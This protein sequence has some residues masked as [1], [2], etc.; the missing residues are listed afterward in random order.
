MTQIDDIY[1]QLVTRVVTEGQTSKGDIRAHYADG[2]PAHTVYIPNAISVTFT[3][4]MGLPII[5]TKPV[6]TKSMLAELDW[7]WRKMSNNVEEL[8]QA[9]ST[10]WDEWEKP[11]GT[12]GPAYGAQL[13]KLART[14]PDRDLKLNQVEYVIHELMNN[15]DHV[16]L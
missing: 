6:A 8:R 12:I 4:E 5:T 7:I 3:P 1:K 10:I 11:D 15:Q 9:G 14:V 13:R 16:E 2:K